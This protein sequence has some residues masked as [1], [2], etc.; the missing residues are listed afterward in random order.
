MAKQAKRIEEE[1]MKESSG[2]G[3]N[4]STILELD[5]NLE[6]M[7]DFELLPDGNY[8]AEISQA[9]MRTSP[10]GNDYYYIIFNIHPDDFPPDYAVENAPEGIKLVYAR[11]QKPDAGNR[12]SITAVKNFMR[13]LGMSLKTSTINPGD[14]EGKKASLKVGHQEWN[15]DE[16]NTIMGVEALD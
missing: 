13:A 3:G 11:I 2:K 15:G 6:D 1:D 4:S 16:I 7:E 12:R 14:W 8:P 9:E 5:M 10:K